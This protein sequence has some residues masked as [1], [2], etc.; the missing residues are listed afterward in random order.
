M[1]QPALILS[2]IALCAR[3]AAAEP[4]AAV[5]PA[6]AAE[7]AAA[8]PA[9]LEH[10][11]LHLVGIGVALGLYISSELGKDSLAPAA[12]RWC[13]P[14]GFDDSV[15]RSLVWGDP[16][17][18]ATISNVTGYVLSPL[19]A[20]GLLLVSSW[21]TGDHWLAFGDDLI[22]VTEAAAYSQLIVQAVKFSV[23][24]QRPYAHYGSLSAA[25]VSNDDN[26]SFLSGHSALTFAIATAAGTVAQRRHYALAPVI[27][28]TGLGLAA[29]T[30]YLRI[31]GDKHYLS[32]VVAGS[33]LGAASG[34]LI[35]RLLGS[36]PRDVTVVP[37]PGG[38][39]L[40]GS[41]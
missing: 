18:A 13:Q 39:A 32:D 19:G 22:A 10:R 2:C 31:A 28:A 4:A 14:P 17:R 40:L 29:T 12:C 6:A 30:A 27:W 11:E 24:R 23:G 21:S 34:V 20:A 8:G 7:P 25:A 38:L 26:L 9:N 16:T 35:P 37:A 36:L 15:R 1:K 41:F 33:A 5:E 3:V